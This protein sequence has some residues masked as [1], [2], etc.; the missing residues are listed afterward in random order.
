MVRAALNAGFLIE[1]INLLLESGAVIDEFLARGHRVTLLCMEHD[2]KYGSIRRED[3]LI[4][5]NGIPDIRMCEWKNLA[6]VA[7]SAGIQALVTVEGL[8]Y[9]LAGESELQFRRLRERGVR[10]ISIPHYTETAS[11]SLEG[12]SLFDRVCYQSDFTMGVHLE[13][14]GAQLSES[15]RRKLVVT[16]SPLL[17]QYEGL[18]RPAIRRKYRLPP[19]RKIVLFMSLKMNVPECWRKYAFAETIPRGILHV[20]GKR[21]FDLLPAVV[22]G[23]KY[24]GIMRSMKSFCRRNDALL[25]VKSRRKNNDPEYVRDHA[26]HFFYDEGFYPSTSIELM[27]IADL[28]IHFQS[29]TVI[30]AVAASVPSISILISQ[31]HIRVKNPLLHRMWFPPGNISPSWHNFQGIVHAV[32]VCEFRRRVSGASWG[33]FP[34]D[35]SRREEYVRRY[36]GYADTRSRARIADLVETVV[37]ERQAA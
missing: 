16:G 17:D 12:L 26:D 9:A 24:P 13:R 29:S 34:F 6:G 23:A 5:K 15:E 8:D 30:E 21:R 3:L 20:C 33:D 36:L 10:I 7:E 18:D 22:F 37:A 35:S 32:E 1:R 19:D 28:C 4:F 11:R 14:C 25:V 2:E 27:S 31:E